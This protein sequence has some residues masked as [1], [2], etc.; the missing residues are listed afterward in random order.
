MTNKAIHKIT[1]HFG[2]ASV[3]PPDHRSYVI[4]VTK[5]NVGIIVDSYGEVLAEKTYEITSKQFDDIQ[6]SLERN[7]GRFGFSSMYS[8]HPSEYNDAKELDK[9]WE[10]VASHIGGLGYAYA[11]ST[12]YGLKSEDDENRVR[13]KRAIYKSVI[14]YTNHVPIEG[15]DVIVNSTPIGTEIGDGFSRLGEHKYAT[16]ALLTH[17]WRIID[18]LA[19]PLVQIWPEVMKDI[20]HQDE[21]GGEQ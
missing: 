17:Q 19:A 10:K 16:H 6:A 21:E 15:T 20:Q 8:R 7:D 1:Y 2:D 9:D 3:P 11:T 12:T 5:D 4:T 13:L 18:P 14:Q